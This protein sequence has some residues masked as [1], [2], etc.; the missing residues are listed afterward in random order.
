MAPRTGLLLGSTTLPVTVPK[1][2]NCIVA[3]PV[4]PSW[5]TVAVA[6]AR[7]LKLGVRARA[8]TLPT[9]R[10]LNTATPFAF[11]VCASP[12]QEEL[13]PSGIV[14]FCPAIGFPAGSSTVNCAEPNPDSVIIA[15]FT[16]PVGA[17]T[18]L[19]L[20]GRLCPADA[21]P[22]WLVLSGVNGAA[23]MT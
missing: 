2:L 14:T 17:A 23:V 7:S 10:L 18:S 15:P 20:T 1:P 3:N 12:S 19:K 11:V 6:E 16:G 5:V 21:T 8:L 13:T 9:G 4:L 22:L